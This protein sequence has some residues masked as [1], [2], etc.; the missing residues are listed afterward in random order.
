[1]T[2]VKRRTRHW[3]ETEG[4]HEIEHVERHDRLGVDDVGDTEVLIAPSLTVVK[5]LA[6][7]EFTGSAQLTPDN[8][9]SVG[10]QGEGQAASNRGYAESGEEGR[11][12]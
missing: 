11:T 3:S 1:M 2:R 10:E 12:R 8:P 5:A 6:R 7:S 4:D 9:L